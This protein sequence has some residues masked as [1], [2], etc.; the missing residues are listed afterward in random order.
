MEQEIFQGMHP[1]LQLGVE[2]KILGKSLL[3]G[4]EISI[5]VGGHVI[6]K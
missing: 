6:L 4:S 1:P 3:R 5:L 2:F